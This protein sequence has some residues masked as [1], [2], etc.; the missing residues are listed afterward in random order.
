MDKSYAKYLLEKTKADYNLIAEEFSRQR[1]FLWEDLKPLSQYV[2]E[3]DRVLDLGCGN[4]RLFK[5][6]ENKNIE[7]FGIDVSEKMIEIAKKNYP[8]GKFL[9]ADVLNLPFPQNY[10]NEVFAIALLHHI[11]SESLRLQSLSEIKRVLKP[12]GLLIISVWNAWKAK[13]K[14]NLL[15]VIKYGF[16]KIIGK[17]KLDFKDVLIPLKKGPILY[18]HFFT[19]R[20]LKKIIKKS[21]FKINKFWIIIKK[22]KHSNIYLIAK[23]PS[24]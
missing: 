8:Q 1:Q 2:Q 9:V 16:L 12:E 5:L 24:L 11:P 7:Y 15:K 13:N 22:G 19:L 21:N 18:Y 20:E 3:G 17:S 10:F 14:S 6:F 23:K 4:G